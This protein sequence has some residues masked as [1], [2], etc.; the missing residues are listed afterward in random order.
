MAQTADVLAGRELPVSDKNRAVFGKHIPGEFSNLPHKKGILSMARFTD[1]NSGT[2]SFSI[3]LGNAPHLDGQYA[4]FGR[5]VEGMDILDRLQ[6]L[7]TKKEVR[8]R[9][10]GRA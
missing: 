6:T 10:G 4:V 8:R 7:E 1:P 9:K 3:L 5:V 2:T